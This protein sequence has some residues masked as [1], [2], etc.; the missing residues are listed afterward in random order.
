MSQKRQN[1][2]TFLRGAGL[3]VGALAG[4]VSRDSPGEGSEPTS[5][6]TPTATPGSTDSPTSSETETETPTEQQPTH[7]WFIERGSVFD[8]FETFSRDWE[9]TFGSAALEG[10]GFLGGTSVRMAT[11]G[12]SRV[13]AE[14]EFVVPEDF[15]G[16][17]FSLAV[18]L[19]STE[20]SAFGV[21]VVLK[22]SGGN[23]RYHTKSIRPSATER[24]VHFDTG[25]DHDRGDFDPRSVSELW[26]EHY[27]GDAESVFHVDDLRTVDK[28]EKG[29]V[30]FS[31]DDAIPGDYE[32]ALPV[33]SK[34]GYEGVCFPPTQYVHENSSPTTAQYREIREKGWDIGGHTLNHESLSDHSKSAQRRILQKNVRE[35]R[36]M[37]LVEEGDPLHFR[38]PFSQYDSATLDVVLEEFDTC[39]VGSGPTKGTGF[40]I[41][42]PRLISFK[43]GEELEEAKTYIDA[44]AEHD[45]LLGFTLHTSY[46]DR[47]HLESLVEHVRE[48]EKRG[49]LEVITL[50][51]L[52]ERVVRP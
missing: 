44:A 40:N 17:D 19:E 52:Y 28:P 7:D 13:R 33:L 5:T 24:W 49:N 31:F 51:D 26:I 9:V 39:I 10:A 47:E 27:A 37:G 45:Q 30:I 2:R 38:T 41:T 48:Y 23:L 11:D 43:S 25:F 1:R 8:D 21:A 12:D 35:L 36:E 6:P 15:S 22:D 34:Y 3:T 18:Q 16:T 29:A 20:K 42:D 14:H 32:Y 4:C 46:I 50:T